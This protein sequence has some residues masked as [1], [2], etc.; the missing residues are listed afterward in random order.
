METQVRLDKNA[1]HPWLCAVALWLTRGTVGAN[2]THRNSENYSNH[3]H[4]DGKG[5]YP[6]DPAERFRKSRHK[7]A[8][9]DDREGSSVILGGLT[10]QVFY[11][12][13]DCLQVLLYTKSIFAG[14]FQPASHFF[15]ERGD[16]LA[17]SFEVTSQTPNF[18]FDRIATRPGIAATYDGSD[19]ERG[20]G[21][22]GDA[23]W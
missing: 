7:N 11:F 18:L 12:L 23:P 9:A 17:D 8:K 4:K 15:F 6:G 10:T 20:V 14:V 5:N 22:V 21:T 2:R 19:T 16:V 3:D 13:L 1:T